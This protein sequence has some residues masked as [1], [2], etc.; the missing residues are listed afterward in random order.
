MSE[1]LACRIL[2]VEAPKLAKTGDG[3]QIDVR[4]IND[5]KTADTF[6]RTLDRLGNV[7][8]RIDN[9]N[10]ATGDGTLGFHIYGTMT[11]MHY[12]YLLEVGYGTCMNPIEITDSKMILVINTDASPLTPGE[13]VFNP[14]INWPIVCGI[15]YISMMGA[16]GQTI[17][18]EAPVISLMESAP[19]HK[20]TFN[21]TGTGGVTDLNPQFTVDGITWK[22]YEAYDIAGNQTIMFG[23]TVT[24][25]IEVDPSNDYRFRVSVIKQEVL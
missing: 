13:M 7:I 15:E 16:P 24:M 12:L 14:S 21:V 2:K 4:Y 22:K 18:Q 11:K 17:T 6:V 1:E 23:I 20:I 10:H 25:P 5:G 8:T 19:V 9:S 3:F